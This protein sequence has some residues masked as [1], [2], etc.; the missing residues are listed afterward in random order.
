MSSSVRTI[1]VA[2]LQGGLDPS[3]R[4]AVQMNTCAQ[5][6]TGVALDLGRQA[7]TQCDKRVNGAKAVH[8]MSEGK[9]PMVSQDHTT[10]G[11]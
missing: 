9:D 8:G 11:A 4:G 5:Q 1:P 7:T 2:N 10:H 6:H 3:Q